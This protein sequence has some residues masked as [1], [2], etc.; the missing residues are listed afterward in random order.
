MVSAK[1]KRAQRQKQY[2]K[3]KDAKVDMKEY[4]ESPIKLSQNEYYEQNKDAKKQ[5]RNQ[6]YEEN[7]DAKS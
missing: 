3:N 5:S 7:K 1:K 6:R 2:M 4:Y